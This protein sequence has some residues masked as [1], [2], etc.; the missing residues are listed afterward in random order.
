[1]IYIQDSFTF[2]EA[3]KEAMRVLKTAGVT[4]G[5]RKLA[6]YSQALTYFILI[7]KEVEETG[8]E[9]TIQLW[10]QAFK[11]RETFVSQYLKELESTDSEILRMMEGLGCSSGCPTCSCSQPATRLEREALPDKPWEDIEQVV[12]GMLDEMERFDESE[13]RKVVNFHNETNKTEQNLSISHTNS[14]TAFLKKSFDQLGLPLSHPKLLG[15]KTKV[16]VKKQSKVLASEGGLKGKH[17]QAAYCYQVNIQHFSSEVKQR[18][19]DHFQ[20]QEILPEAIQSTNQQTQSQTFEEYHQSQDENILYCIHCQHQC[21]SVEDMKTHTEQDHVRCKVC[22]KSFAGNI[23]LQLHMETDHSRTPCPI[24]DEEIET[25]NLKVHLTSHRQKEGF[26]RALED[27]GKI[28]SKAKGSKKDK[29]DLRM[30]YKLFT[31]EKKA[32]SRVTSLLI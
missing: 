26:K 29:V 24:C 17:T 1:M 3:H 12:V 22:K 7:E 8:N 10:V 23:S 2:K 14:K 30:A 5:P 15:P 16:F 18:I 11:D 20:Q 28:T 21:G 19:L 9:K 31:E 27:V 32:D 4:Y 6:S 25:H 13:V